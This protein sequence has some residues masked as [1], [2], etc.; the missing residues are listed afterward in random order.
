MDEENIEKKDISGSRLKTIFIYGLVFV[1]GVLAGN[2]FDAGNRDALKETANLVSQ[3]GREAL[4]PSKAEGVNLSLPLKK[5]TNSKTKAVIPAAIPSPPKA[6]TS[7]DIDA[8]TSSPLPTTSSSISAIEVI[9]APLA[10][11]TSAEVEVAESEQAPSAPVP[12][13]M[14][15]KLLIFEIQITGGPGNS[16]Q[17]FIKIY[18]PTPHSIDAS[19]WKIRKRSSK[20]SEASIKVIPSGTNIASGALLTWAN[21]KDNFAESMGAE[22]SSTASIAADSSIAIFDSEGEI[23]DAVAW[24]EGT[25]QFVEGSPYPNNP[26]A[27]QILRRKIGGANLQDTDNNFSDFSV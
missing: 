27:G 24:G 1:L 9:S 13:A 14:A 2:I 4:A 26:E 20:G 6:A 12:V 10:A 3:T 7:S 25:G 21:S 15:T 18:N 8:A 22:I 23:I 19:G 16:E 11:S 17:D 5:Q